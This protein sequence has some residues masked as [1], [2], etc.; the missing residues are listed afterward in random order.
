MSEEPELSQAKL[1][2]VTLFMLAMAIYMT[3]LAP[4]FWTAWLG[5]DAYVAVANMRYRP[6]WRGK[7]SKRTRRTIAAAGIIGA[8][9]P[10]VF[11]NGVAALRE[12]QGTTPVFVAGAIAMTIR[13]IA[14]A[15][16][17]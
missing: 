4:Q 1:N 16:R 10:C 6:R 7:F 11:L 9:A 8:V 17:R 12:M 2:I 5:M 13:R 14:D 15:A 3:L